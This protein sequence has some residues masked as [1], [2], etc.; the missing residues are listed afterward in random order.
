VEST[1]KS[2]S[3][4]ERLPWYKRLFSPSASQT[5]TTHAYT[6]DSPESKRSAPSASPAPVTW[7]CKL[8]GFAAKSRSLVYDHLKALHRDVLDRN[9][10]I[11]E[12]T[13]P[14]GQR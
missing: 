3:S 2:G 6:Q 14:N 7:Y 12:D 5:A 4:S 13:R 8:C 11:S 10:N 9:G 1:T